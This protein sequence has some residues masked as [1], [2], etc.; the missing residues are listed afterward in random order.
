MTKH[1]NSPSYRNALKCG[2]NKTF[3]VKRLNLLLTRIVTRIDK[4]TIYLN[5]EELSDKEIKS[6]IGLLSSLFEVKKK[7]KSEMKE[8]TGEADTGENL[9]G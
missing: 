1:L 9:F 6:K 7:I 8:T 2:K 5:Q 3:A 4:I